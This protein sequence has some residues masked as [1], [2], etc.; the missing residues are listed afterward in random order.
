M[1]KDM[2]KESIF[3]KGRFCIKGGAKML[4]FF[5]FSFLGPFFERCADFHVFLMRCSPRKV[6]E[7]DVLLKIVA[8]LTWCED[9]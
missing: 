2:K 5:A 3:C 9:I 6:S 8:S 7:M 1:E 4:S